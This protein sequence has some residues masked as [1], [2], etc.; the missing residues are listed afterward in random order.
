MNQSTIEQTDD[1][2]LAQIRAYYIEGHFYDENV[3][4]LLGGFVR[5]T[6]DSTRER[7][8]DSLGGLTATQRQAYA[9]NIHALIRA[10]VAGHA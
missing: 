3:D 4:R 10:I 2:W 6:N 7:I 5:V 8:Y 9:A 1:E